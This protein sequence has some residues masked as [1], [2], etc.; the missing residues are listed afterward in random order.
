MGTQALI[1]HLRAEIRELEALVDMLK[2]A[3]FAA[4]VEKV[5]E[6]LIWAERL[7]PQHRALLGMLFQ[8]WPN[9]VGSYDLLDGLPSRDHAH[10]RDVTL[11]HVIVSQV[12]AIFGHEAVVTHRAVGYSLG[13]GMRT[14]ME[15]G[16]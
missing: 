12:R 2:G 3:L 6:R 14:V 4:G 7:T 9:A 15:K 5:P 8:A 10:D 11:V 13:A 16:E 1:E